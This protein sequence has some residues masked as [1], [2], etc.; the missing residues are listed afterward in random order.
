MIQTAVINNMP[1]G[2][3]PINIHPQMGPLPYSGNNGHGVG[4]GLMGPAGGGLGPNP[5]LG[6]M[7]LKPAAE[8]KRIDVISRILFPLSFAGFNVMYWSYYFTMSYY[9]TGRVSSS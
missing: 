5:S 4:G 9:S 7:G 3:I 6:P 8:A 2:G 1:P